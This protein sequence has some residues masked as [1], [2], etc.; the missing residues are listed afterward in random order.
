MR[1]KR[2]AI[3]AAVVAALAIGATGLTSSAQAQYVPGGAC[4]SGTVAC[5]AG[6][7]G[8]EHDST[9]RHSSMGACAECHTP[10]KGK[11]TLLM[12][13]QQLSQNSFSWSDATTT[14]A[15]TTLPKFSGQSYQ[16]MSVKCLSCHD[17]SVAAGTGNWYNNTTQPAGTHY[18]SANDNEAPGGNLMGVHPLAVPYPY[19]Q[20][21]STYN[22]S[23]TGAGIALSEWVPN[24][25]AGAIRL[26]NDSTGTGRITAGAVLAKTG[27]ECGS[28]HDIHNGPNAQGPYLLRG[29]IYGNVKGQG[30]MGYLCFECHNK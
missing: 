14:T 3:E 27:I 19:M 12:W 8:S 15:G 29:Q 13:N 6:F 5:G 23:T 2:P 22:N 7:T 24:P 9:T 21:G 1:V 28:C 20:A 17:G 16:G 4:S 26:Y 25:S 30:A 11:S 18:V 10:H